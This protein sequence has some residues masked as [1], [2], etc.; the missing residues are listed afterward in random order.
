MEA[1][2]YLKMLEL[3][4]KEPLS[5]ADVAVS[6]ACPLIGQGGIIEQNFAK[7]PDTLASLDVT[8]PTPPGLG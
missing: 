1:S 4:G 7:A 3:H 5:G 6:A 8:P 2:E